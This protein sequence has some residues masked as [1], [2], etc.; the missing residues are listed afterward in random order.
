MCTLCSRAFHHPP[1]AQ[2]RTKLLFR[3]PTVCS[4]HRP[5]HSWPPDLQWSSTHHAPTT[6]HTA[7]LSAA[8]PL[9][10]HG[11]HLGYGHTSSSQEGCELWQAKKAKPPQVLV[12][13]GTAAH[14]DGPLAMSPWW[15]HSMHGCVPMVVA[16]CV[17]SHPHS[18]GT[19]CVAVSPWWWHSAHCRVPIVVALNVRSQPHGGGTQCV[20][21]TPKWWQSAHG[22]VPMVVTP[23]VWL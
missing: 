17:W 13:S 7:P 23:H 10:L 15:W 9:T 6:T 21:V 12:P 3:R 2:N 11:N 1:R 5:A 20:A 19:P 22:H 8:L 14:Q 16:L 4:L 18:C